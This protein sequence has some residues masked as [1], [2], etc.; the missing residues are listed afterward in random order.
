MNLT[1]RSLNSIHKLK[2][3]I[4][5]IHEK[6]KTLHFSHRELHLKAEQVIKC[7]DTRPAAN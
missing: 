5:F 6:N 4:I 2:N 3:T 7:L 1:N